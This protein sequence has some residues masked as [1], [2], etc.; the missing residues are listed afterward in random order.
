MQNTFLVRWTLKALFHC[1]LSLLNL[2]QMFQMVFMLLKQC[3]FFITSFS[4]KNVMTSCEN[5][6]AQSFNKNIGQ[7]QCCFSERAGRGRHLCSFSVVV[8]V[9]H[10]KTIRSEDSS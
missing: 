4:N 10:V 7:S 2:K 8:V 6:I 3:V 1:A 9:F 5:V